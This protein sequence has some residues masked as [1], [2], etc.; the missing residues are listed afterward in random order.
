MT[1][2]LV[3]TTGLVP[4]NVK[5]ADALI[6]AA[7]GVI[8][9]S[10]ADTLFFQALNLLGAARA[11]IVECL[12]SPGIILFA[13]LI[14]GEKLSILASMGAL[15]I[16][17]GVLLTSAD[18]ADK[19]ISRSDFWK[20]TTLGALS[21]LL[22]G[23]AIVVVKPIIANYPTCWS[24]TMRMGGGT[25]GLILFT[26][27]HKDRRQI[28]GILRPQPAWKVALPGAFLGGYVGFVVWMG[29]FKFAQANVA[30]LL[31]QL[32]SFFVVVLAVLIL[33][34]RLTKWKVVALIFALTGTVLVLW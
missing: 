12:Y 10:V 27:I 5:L 8:G 21:M 17:I 30:G 16:I 24:A 19:E 2:T 13:Y 9:I 22:M 15:L 18:T 7:S 4:A 33:K 34:E 3:M 23:I 29:G 6:I 20:G 32:S 28:W 31:T 14:L 11:A 25:L 26:L 1:A